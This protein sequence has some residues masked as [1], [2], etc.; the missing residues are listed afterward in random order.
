MRRMAT[1]KHKVSHNP[2]AFSIDINDFLCQLGTPVGAIP[3]TTGAGVKFISL[4][5]Y[6]FEYFDEK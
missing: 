2:R 6:S 3:L 4:Y 1:G 5:M